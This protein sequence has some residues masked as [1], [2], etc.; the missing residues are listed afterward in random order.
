MAVRNEAACSKYLCASVWAS[1]FNSVKLKSVATVR[2][3]KKWLS[4]GRNRHSARC[5]VG[6]CLPPAGR[7]SPLGATASP[8]LGVVSALGGGL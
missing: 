6:F 1:S 7:G 4:F 8:A 3:G 5:R 2:E